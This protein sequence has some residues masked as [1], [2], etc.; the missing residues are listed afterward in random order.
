MYKDSQLIHKFFLIGMVI[1]FIGLIFILIVQIS[2]A[3][4][5]GGGFTSAWM[6]LVLLALFAA[7]FLNAYKMIV[8]IDEKHLTVGFGLIK[9][10]IALKEIT[11]CKPV[12]HSWGK[13]WQCGVRKAKD[14]SYLYL[15]RGNEGVEIKTKETKCIISTDKGKEICS[16]LKKPQTKRKVP[17][18]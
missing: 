13:W 11:S 1:A 8:T 7:A 18:T 3:R 9:K 10:R 15:A 14:G 2:F 6:S 12:K 4:L 17:K 5:I 16:F